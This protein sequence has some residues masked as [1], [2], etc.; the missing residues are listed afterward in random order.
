MASAQN[1]ARFIEPMLLLRTNRLPEGDAWE[2]EVKLDGYRA[3]AFKSGGRAHLRSRNDKDFGGKYPGIVKALSTLPDETVID[4]E[5]VAFRQAMIERRHILNGVRGDERQSRSSP[6][7]IER[8][9]HGVA[10]PHKQASKTSACRRAMA[11]A[12]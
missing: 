5:V 6:R 3:I 7:R 8:G 9:R 12:E 4:G 1:K 10:C 2:Y 11:C